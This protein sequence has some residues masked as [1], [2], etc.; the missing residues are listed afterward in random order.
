MGSRG[1]LNVL[2][3]GVGSPAEPRS[4]IWRLWLQGDEVYV[5]ARELLRAFKVSLHKSGIWR[6]AFVRAL[7]TKER[8][9]DRL[10]HRWQRPK[11]DHR[12]ATRAVAIIV[13]PVLPQRPFKS[14]SIVDSS[15]EWLPLPPPNKVMVLLVVFVRSGVVVDP[16]MFGGDQLIGRLKKKNGE[17]VCLV[18]HVLNPPAPMLTQIHETMLGLKIHV[19][20][21]P[22]ETSLTAR[23]WSAHWDEEIRESNPPIIYDIPLGWENVICDG[24]S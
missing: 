10:V 9:S 21:E 2:R 15:V 7:E 1:S 22:S 11:A 6:M 19:T 16:I 20:G 17:T 5:G 13:P 4:S 18:A 23:A 12:G 8:S 3:V 24:S 14:R